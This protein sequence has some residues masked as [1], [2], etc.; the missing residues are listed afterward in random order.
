[1][2]SFVLA[3]NPSTVVKAENCIYL[4]LA[5]CLYDFQV[6][7]ECFCGL[8]W[9]ISVGEQS[10]NSASDIVDSILFSSG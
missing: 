3:T 5:L 9:V 8:Y 1:M 2:K 4:L 6:H 7:G 10:D